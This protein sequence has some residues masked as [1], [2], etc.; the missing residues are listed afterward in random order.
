MVLANPPETPIGYDPFED[1]LDF[2]SR[3]Q[4]EQQQDLLDL[5]RQLNANISRLADY[6][7][8]QREKEAPTNIDLGPLSG[9]NNAGTAGGATYVTT[10]RFRVTDILI[11]GGAAGDNI[12]LMIG[13]RPYNFF[14]TG[15][16]AFVPFPIQID[17]GIDI[18]VR[19]VTTPANV[20]WTFMLFGYP[21]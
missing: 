2:A 21:E 1:P 15:T 3:V 20:A 10:Q 4:A 17:R 14:G 18:N 16:M 13:S 19:D 9:Q 8:R 6:S 5:L 12:R 11:G 7:N